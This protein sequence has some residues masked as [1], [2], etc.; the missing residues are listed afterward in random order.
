MFGKPVLSCLV[1]GIV[2]LAEE[3]GISGLTIQT[4]TDDFAPYVKSKN[5][6]MENLQKNLDTLFT[7][8]SVNISGLARS[9][10]YDGFLYIKN[11]ERTTTA[12]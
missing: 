12:G 6:G 2:Q 7:V 11:S 8:L 1:K 10:N 4:V 9:L 5:T 3:K